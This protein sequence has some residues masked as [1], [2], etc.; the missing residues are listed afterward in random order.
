MLQII[1]NDT[2]AHEM[3]QLPTGLQLEIMNQFHVLP[4]QLDS[5]ALD[6][7]FGR[8]ERDGSVYY[9]LR[10][11]D[12]RIYFQITPSGLVVHRVMDRNTLK[13]F[14]FRSKLPLVEEDAALQSNAGFWKLLDEAGQ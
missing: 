10:A 14:F 1:F 9:R 2:S 11:K 5:A 7:R 8:L 4:D 3:A 6:E 13:D 12:H